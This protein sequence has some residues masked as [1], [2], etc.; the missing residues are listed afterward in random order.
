MNRYGWRPSP[1]VNGEKPLDIVL[2]SYEAADQEKSIRGQRWVVEHATMIRP[3]QIERFAR[4]GVL[5]SAQ[6]QPYN[7]SENMIRTW[8][9]ERADRIVPMREMLDHGLNVSS[10]SDWAG[11]G[12]NSPFIPFYFYVTRKAANGT[13]MGAAQKITR[14]E[15]LRVVTMNNAYLT[16]EEKVK[17]SIEADKIAD[18]VILSQD[19]LTVAEEQ[20]RSIHPLATYVAGQKVFSSM[21]EG[22]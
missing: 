5:V 10:G 16:F 3:D 11:G 6:F 14:Q 8:G 4:L 21:S 20:I 7:G 13:V 1:H 12:P 17:G 2:E 9:K 22:F 19:I 15:A 18:F